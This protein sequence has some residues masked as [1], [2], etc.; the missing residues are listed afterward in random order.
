[1]RHR[2]HQKFSQSFEKRKQFPNIWYSDPVS[3]TRNTV[4]RAFGMI[5]EG[6]FI[7]SK[8]GCSLSCHYLFTCIQMKPLARLWRALDCTINLYGINQH[9]CFYGDLELGQLFFLRGP[10]CY[11]LCESQQY[12]FIP[13]PH[14]HL[15]LH[16]SL[17]EFH[18]G[19]G[20]Q[21]WLLS[22][23]LV[24]DSSARRLYLV[25]IYEC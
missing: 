16:S 17:L 25:T 18:S 13:P 2:D 9:P 20:G 6:C 5:L 8:W 4:F 24:L 15:T 7:L 23:F 22:T 3:V 19:L 11:K 12:L 14:N 1:M 21:W 10:G